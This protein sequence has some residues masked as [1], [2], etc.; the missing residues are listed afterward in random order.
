MGGVGSG[1]GS[2][3]DEHTTGN[4][5]TN[6]RSA[7]VSGA[8]CGAT[9]RAATTV[10]GASYICGPSTVWHQIGRSSKDELVHR[11]RATRDES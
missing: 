3:K 10:R 4:D 2:G 6:Q 7:D 9:K 11:I 8:I 1:S 5:T